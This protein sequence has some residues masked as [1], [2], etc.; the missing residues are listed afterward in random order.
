MTQKI[1]VH[2]VSRFHLIKLETLN[3]HEKCVHD[4]HSSL[5]CRRFSDEK[6]NCSPGFSFSVFYIRDYQTSQKNVS[7][8][9]IL[10]YFAGA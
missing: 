7:L 5:V 3:R 6:N 10:A 4:K 1:I 9:N 8:T 2:L